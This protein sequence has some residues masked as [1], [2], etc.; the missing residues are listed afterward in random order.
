MDFVSLITTNDF[1]GLLSKSNILALIV[2]SVISGIAIGQSGED[3]KRVSSMLNSL[4]TVIMKIVSILMIAAP[5]GLGAYFAS[6]MASK[7]PELVITFAR[8]IGL[9]FITSIKVVLR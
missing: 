9:F 2:M 7:D 3:G 8:T 4:N 1:V 5:V 6:T